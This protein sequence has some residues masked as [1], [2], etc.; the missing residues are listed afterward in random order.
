[1][2]RDRW[3]RH[4][5]VARYGE[6]RV[7]TSI[8]SDGTTDRMSMSAFVAKYMEQ[9]SDCSRSPATAQ[10]DE[11]ANLDADDQAAVLKESAVGIDSGSEI[12][13]ASR[14]RLAQLRQTL[15]TRA[16]RVAKDGRSNAVSRSREGE[17]TA[18]SSRIESPPRLSLNLMH[19][20]IAMGHSLADD[21]A[22]VPAYFPESRELRVEAGRLC[23]RIST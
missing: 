9:T 14:R 23:L 20:G 15:G 7:G 13:S 2:A 21:V 16:H 10:G 6:T 17:D 11:V 1:M 8:S 19:S 22:G 4:R 5:L 18:I 12:F 3:Q